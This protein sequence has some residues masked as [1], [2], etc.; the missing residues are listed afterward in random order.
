MKFKFEPGGIHI[1]A[2]AMETLTEQDIS[3]GLKRHLEGDWGEVCDEDKAEN[4]YSVDKRLR[5][6]SAYTSES[7]DKFWIISEADRSSTTIL[8]PEEY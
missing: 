8:L 5:I 1:T 7:G 6:L 4:D 2:G 3:K